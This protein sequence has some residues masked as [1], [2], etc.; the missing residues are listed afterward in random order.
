M[1][2][3]ALSHTITNIKFTN[4]SRGTPGASDMSM[5]VY[6]DP[7]KQGG[8]GE[9]SDIA[10]GTINYANPWHA[11]EAKLFYN[12]NNGTLEISTKA[13]EDYDNEEIKKEIWSDSNTLDLG[14][15]LDLR[16][17]LPSDLELGTTWL[18]SVGSEVQGTLSL[19]SGDTKKVKFMS[20]T[21]DTGIHIDFVPIIKEVI[22]EYSYDQNTIN[23]KIEGAFKK[24]WED[25]WSKTY[26][27]TNFNTSTTYNFTITAK[28]KEYT[29]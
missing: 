18:K 11:H 5:E 19:W 17:V 6:T 16:Y 2:R 26:L 15:S 21:T 23:Q 9:L 20:G 25:G 7:Q 24:G 1:A 14:N 13:L 29:C 27:E 8:Q 22:D 28:Y 4:I 12:P 10:V 3:D